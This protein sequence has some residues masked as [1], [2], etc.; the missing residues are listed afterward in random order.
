[1]KFLRLSALMLAAT[2][3]LAS[4]VK[5]SYDAPPD[6]SQYDPAL[7]VHT[8]LKN[9]SNMTVGL[10]SGKWRQ[11][12]DTTVYGVVVADDR[13]GNYYKQIVIEDTSIGGV[14]LYID[15]SYLYADYPVGRRVYV[16]LKG[17]Y[18]MN[19]SGIPEIVYAVDAGG[20]T[21]AIPS[22]LVGNYIVKG[23]YPDNSVSAK[24][25]TFDD[26]KFTANNYLNC[27]V[28]ATGT[29]FAAGS[30][31]ATYAG[32]P[33]AGSGTNRILENCD[34]STTMTLRNSNYSNFQPYLIP[35]GQGSITC[36]VSTFGGVAQLLIRDTTDVKMTS[37][38]CP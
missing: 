1:M 13:S 4:C 33:S 8:T 34:H 12:G 2:A 3:L 16:K 25:M 27:L 20:N 32:S 29:Q 5:K 35:A 7:P 36:I 28:T 18:L 14:I 11:M 9:I 30:Y 31:G 22:G 15:K 17:L 23:K 37:P 21:T 10:G 38:R 26:L 19:Y 6:S 24:V